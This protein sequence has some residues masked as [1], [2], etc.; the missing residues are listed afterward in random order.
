MSDTRDQDVIICWPSRSRPPYVQLVGRVVRPAGANL[1]NLPEPDVI[2]PEP[3]NNYP[4]EFPEP[5]DDVIEPEDDGDEEDPE[6]GD[7]V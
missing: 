6:F 5:D 3:E 7:E 2:D 4:V 1:D